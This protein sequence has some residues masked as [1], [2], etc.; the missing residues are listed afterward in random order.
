M[1]SRLAQLFCPFNSA[2][3]ARAGW[4]QLLLVINPNLLLLNH[5]KNPSVSLAFLLLTPW[6]IQGQTVP[7]GTAATGQLA[8]FKTP[9]ETPYAV[10]ERGAHYSVWQKTAYETGADGQT[11]P[12]IHQYIELATGLNFQDELTGQWME[13]KEIIESFPGGAVARHGQT[14][15]IFANDLATPGAI[16][17]QTPDGLRIRSHILGLSYFDTASGESVLIAQVTNCIGVVVPP[18]Q[19]L[20]QNAFSEFKAS[21]LYTYTKAGGIEQDVILEERPPLPEDFSLD[22]RTTHLQILTEF[23]AP[24]TPAV[25]DSVIP[26][27][28]KDGQNLLDESLDFGALKIGPGKAFILDNDANPAEA[29][30]VAKQW[31]LLEG[32]RVLVEEVTI[33]AAAKQLDTLPLPGHAGLDPAKNPAHRTAS[34]HRALPARSLALRRNRNEALKTNANTNN[35]E[36]AKLSVRRQGFVLDYNTLNSSLTNYTFQGDTTYYI[37]GAVSLN[38]TNTFEGG[39]VLKY[40]TNGSVTLASGASSSITNPAVI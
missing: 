22:S 33:P 30:P 31:L 26:S 38:K 34:T 4:F 5:M 3:F 21:V 36:M 32:R 23:L 13:S 2:P 1:F 12:H 37:S 24:P 11:G 10:T 19:V 6:L 17:L 28:A 40:A 20:Y 9:A 35:M 8:G 25:K 39:A 15:V 14:K 18:N 7:S 16:D 29:I 27:G